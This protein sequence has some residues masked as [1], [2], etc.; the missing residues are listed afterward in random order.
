MIRDTNH[1]G[2]NVKN[3]DASIRFYRDILGFQQL[4]GIV[5][6]RDLHC[7]VQYMKIPDGVMVEF[8]EYYPEVCETCYEVTQAGVYRHIAFT[9]DKKEDL[10]EYHQKLIDAREAFPE[11]KIADQPEYLP[12][13][14]LDVLLF[15]DPNGVE[16]EL[17]LKRAV[18]R[19]SWPIDLVKRR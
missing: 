8:I 4:G 16:I 12:Y 2:I 11:I 19:Y 5:D 9:V 13:L 15:R 3:M 10:Q 17:C 1:I 6:Q 14:D 7:R 18:D